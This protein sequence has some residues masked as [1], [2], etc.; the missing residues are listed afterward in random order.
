[1]LMNVYMYSLSV[2]S[3]SCRGAACMCNLQHERIY[4]SYGLTI[5]H[6]ILPYT[7]KYTVL[8]SIYHAILYYI[9]ALVV[10][11]F[12]FSVGQSKFTDDIFQ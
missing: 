6:G 12:Y 9:V 4:Y 2:H 10:P 1:M 3:V 5:R 8:A 11:K 7:S